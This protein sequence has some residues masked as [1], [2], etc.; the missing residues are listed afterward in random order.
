MISVAGTE[1]VPA[2]DVLAY[3]RVSARTS[4]PY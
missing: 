3:G 1:T 2:T 4:R